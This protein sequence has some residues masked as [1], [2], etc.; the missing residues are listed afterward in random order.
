MTKTKSAG[1]GCR[2]CRHYTPEGRRGGL[3]QQLN[4]PVQSHWQAC[5]LALPP[6]A[7]SWEGIEEFTEG[8]S[9]KWILK[10]ELITQPILN[11]TANSA[12]KSGG[13]ITAT[14]ILAAS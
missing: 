3:C 11:N 8:L 4:V 1:L 13:E 6:F 14:E 5:T 7:P 12:F 10:G 9:T 2:H